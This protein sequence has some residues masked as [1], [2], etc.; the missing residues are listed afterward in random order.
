MSDW[1][2]T[3]CERCGDQP[4]FS[5]IPRS[6]LKGRKIPSGELPRMEPL[7][8]HEYNVGAVRTKLGVLAHNPHACLCMVASLLL[9]DL[10][11]RE[12][13]LAPED[14]DALAVAHYAQ[15][16][17]LYKLAHQMVNHDPSEPMVVDYTN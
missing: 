16:F 10:K 2:Y 4:N 8:P 5:S 13:S 6:A 15:A 11:I 17:Q 1:A 9:C 7:S 3:T 14:L 12:K